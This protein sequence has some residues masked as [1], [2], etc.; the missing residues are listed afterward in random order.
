MK[1]GKARRK[2]RGVVVA[3]VCKGEGFLGDRVSV[4]AV[5]VSVVPA[6]EAAATLILKNEPYKVAGKKGA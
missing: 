1:R 5:Q 2:R 3:Q 4:S 6:M